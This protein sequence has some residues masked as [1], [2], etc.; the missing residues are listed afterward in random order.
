VSLG[1]HTVE[2]NFVAAVDSNIGSNHKN[3]AE[4]SFRAM[5]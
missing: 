3:A 4:I 1:F 5:R 2:I